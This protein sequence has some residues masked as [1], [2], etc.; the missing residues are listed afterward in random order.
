MRVLGH[1]GK[2]GE[3]GSEGART[4]GDLVQAKRLLG[5]L[6]VAARPGFPPFFLPRPA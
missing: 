5:Q 2:K 6:P 3:E 1:G 4:E